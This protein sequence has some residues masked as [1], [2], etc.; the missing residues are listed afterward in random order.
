MAGGPR[1]VPAN[2]KAF[3][4]EIINSTDEWLKGNGLSEIPNTP[5]DDEGVEYDG[6]VMGV[7]SELDTFIAQ[8]GNKLRMLLKASLEDA[9][10]EAAL[11]AELPGNEQQRKS[12]SKYS[13]LEETLGTASKMVG[14]IHHDLL[15]RGGSDLVV[16]LRESLT[17]LRNEAEHQLIPLVEEKQDPAL[18]GDVHH[19][20][21][22][23]HCTQSTLGTTSTTLQASKTDS[24][25]I[26][27]I[28]RPQTPLDMS[29]IPKRRL[30]LDPNDQFRPS[31]RPSNSTLPGGNGH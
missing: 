24:E 8:T 14:R 21:A 18:P 31:K 12:P 6:N 23:A 10:R 2:P 9:I 5:T 30:E 4:E 3:F 1:G 27:Q 11:R 25:Q 22:N 17:S 19:A 7:L 16:K 29:K 28:K 26:Q 13:Q 20:Y 15:R